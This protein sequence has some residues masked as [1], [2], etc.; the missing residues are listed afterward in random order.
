MEMEETDIEVI[1]EDLCAMYG[2]ER[3]PGHVTSDDGTPVFCTHEC[4]RVDADA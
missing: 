2:C 1:T 4:H 3:C